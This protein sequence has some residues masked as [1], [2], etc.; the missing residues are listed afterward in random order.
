[1]EVVKTQNVT[2]VL[3]IINEWLSLLTNEFS[4]FALPLFVELLFPACKEEPLTNK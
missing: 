2:P 3:I 4:L 1:M